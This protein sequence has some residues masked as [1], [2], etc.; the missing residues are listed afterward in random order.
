[1]V[2]SLYC[3]FVHSFSASSPDQKGHLINFLF[4]DHTPSPFQ[5]PEH[6]PDQATFGTRRRQLQPT[7]SSS[8]RSPNFHPTNLSSIISRGR[9]TH[10]P[11][12]TPKLVSAPNRNRVDSQRIA[13]T[14]SKTPP[15]SGSSL[16][17]EGRPLRDY[18]IPSF[19]E[20]IS[21]LGIDSSPHSF[22]SL[23]FPASSA[24]HTASHRTAVAPTDPA[25]SIPLREPK[26]RRLLTTDDI[27]ATIYPHF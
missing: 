6:Q 22:S 8:F 26:R 9:S 17:W 27:N 11:R 20:C 1:M 18:A 5:S 23:A 21:Y 7:H 24:P 4:N 19:F 16:V 3:T 10:I 12:F 25:I 15:P 13:T 2:Q 14:N